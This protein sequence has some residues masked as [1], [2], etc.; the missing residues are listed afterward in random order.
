MRLVHPKFL[1][2][3][4]TVWEN[5]KY[6]IEWLL[7]VKIL[8]CDVFFGMFITA[9]VY[10][11]SERKMKL[12]EVKGDLFGAKC[13]LA[14]CV[15]SD[16]H[17]SAGIARGFKNKF[18]GQEVLRAGGWLVGDAAHLRL[19][20]GRYV[21]YLVTKCRYYH[22]PTLE[23]LTLS[24]EQLARRVK[25]LDLKE[26]AVQPT[27]RMWF[28]PIALGKCKTDI[29]KGVSIHGYSYICLLIVIRLFL[30]VTLL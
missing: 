14:H 9:C 7:G 18:G 30:Y 6:V 26:L 10:D 29:A 24:L 17:M 21:F 25:L 11:H 1:L 4:N 2:C 22:L 28:R 3:V 23:N 12:V 8:V 15:S 27:P 13:S 16:F 5:R 19:S 20:S